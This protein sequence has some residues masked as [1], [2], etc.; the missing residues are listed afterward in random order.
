MD[1][2]S[3]LSAARTLL[4][5]YFGPTPIVRAESL[6]TPGRDIYLK[7]ETVLPTGSFKVRGALYAFSRIDRSIVTEVVAASTGNHGAAVAFA[8]QAFGLTARIFLP[9]AS[10]PVKIARIREFGATI[11]EGGTDLSA[12]IDAAEHYAKRQGAF[13][14]HD[15]QHPDIPVGAATIGAEL[16]E[17]LANPTAVYIPMGDTALIRG[18]AAALRQASH[19][20]HIVGVVAENAPAYYQSWRSGSV[21]ETATA[22]TIADGLAITRPLESN[23]TAI[24]ELL[25]DV[26]LVSEREMLDAIGLLR[27]REGIQSEPS[28]AASVAALLRDQPRA[29]ARVAVVTGRNISPAIRV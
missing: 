14:L 24:R 17:Q 18:V 8:A 2:L 13:F 9:N 1:R 11:V 3:T 6:S 25:D 29:G 23:V 12:A 16:L 4:A 27:S 21:V 10:N 7:N 5:Q 22:A 28:G 20:I 26:M 19:R 15:A